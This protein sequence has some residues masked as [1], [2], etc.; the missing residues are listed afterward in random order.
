MWTIL[1]PALVLLTCDSLFIQQNQGALKIQDPWD[2]GPPP[3]PKNPASWNFSG[4]HTWGF[5]QTVNAQSITL[6]WPEHILLLQRHDPQ[7]GLQLSCEGTHREAVPGKEFALADELAKGNYS[8]SAS[9]DDTYRIVDVKIGDKVFIGFDRRNGVDICTAIRIVRR[10][11]GVVP[12]APG[13]KPTDVHRH[14]EQANAD[15]AW[16]ENKVPYP[17]KYWPSYLGQDGNFY[18]GPYPSHSKVIVFVLPVAPAPREIQPRI[19]PQW[20]ER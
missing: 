12:P 18:V 5:V 20:R 19:P 13:E 2:S 3:H 10:P 6:Y 4:R 7:T 14:H 17:R 15:Q 1:A 16:E 8:N 11:G 9:I